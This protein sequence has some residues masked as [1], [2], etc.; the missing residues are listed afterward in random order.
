MSKEYPWINEGGI[1][2]VEVNNL[3]NPPNPANAGK[4]VGVGEDG[5]ATLLESG[6]GTGGLPEVTEEDDGD[7][8]TVV[9]G[10]WG[11]AEPQSGEPVVLYAVE[12]A[13]TDPAFELFPDVDEW[14]NDVYSGVSLTPDGEPLTFSELVELIEGG[15]LFI[16]QI[17]AEPAK[18]YSYPTGAYIH[19]GEYDG[20]YV[21]TAEIIDN[22]NGGN[23]TFGVEFV[24]DPK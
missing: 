23:R 20:G 14:T 1:D 3:V 21:I 12:A 7:V 9:D 16:I 22:F 6:G 10:A 8:L 18:Y 2:Y 24:G 5:R 17:T 13:D 15:N 4:V 11:K 19:T